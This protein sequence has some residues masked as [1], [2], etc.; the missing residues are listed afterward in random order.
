MRGSGLRVLGGG[1]VMTVSD[2]GDVAIAVMDVLGSSVTGLMPTEVSRALWAQDIALSVEISQ[3]CGCRWYRP[4][5]CGRG[6]TFRAH[7][8]R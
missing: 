8:S 1:D 2:A 6:A 3:F 5:R 4:R 7:C